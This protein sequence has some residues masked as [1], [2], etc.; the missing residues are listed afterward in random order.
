[1]PLKGILMASKLCISFDFELGWGV[2]DSALWVQREKA[3]WYRNLRPV[4]KDLFACIKERELNTTWA[5]VS[6]M[7]L[8]SNQTYETSHLRC[9]FAQKIHEFT[10]NS[11]V[12]TRSALDVVD[13]F[14]GV[15][16]HTE[17]ASHT[18][19]HVYP[20]LAGVTSAEYATD[21]KL[22]IKHLEEYFKTPI[23]SVVLPR[24]D[25]AYLNKLVKVCPLNYRVN[26]AVYNKNKRCLKRFSP[27]QSRIILGQFGETYQN[28]S[29]FFNPNPG[30]KMQLA[31]QLS[32]R[33]QLWSLLHKLRTTDEVFHVWLHPFNL[34]QS[35]QH[36][37]MFMHFLKTVSS[38]ID[39]GKTNTI[40]MAELGS[41]T[42]VQ[43]L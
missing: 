9:S 12:Q 15:M 26:P 37:E 19:T 4:L 13:L 39:I 31:K 6:S 21:I 2:L 23:R 34:V 24:D 17:I 32:F 18:A 20:S 33:C 28:G 36:K 25:T 10:A 1:M 38:L 16:D 35:T 22:S 27:E 30:G 8:Q 5:L 41:K 40:T 3:G 14:D 29:L 43:I 42:K 11:E 7:L